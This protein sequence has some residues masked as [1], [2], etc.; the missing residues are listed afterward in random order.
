MISMI[1]DF[2]CG[3]D[4]IDEVARRLISQLA[5]EIE[6]PRTPLK[7]G[8]SSNLVFSEFKHV[9]MRILDILF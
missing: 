3:F 8:Y 7:N 4:D 9:D 5:S 1:E 2:V 6:W